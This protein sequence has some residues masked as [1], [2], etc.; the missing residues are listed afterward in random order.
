MQGALSLNGGSGREYAVEVT[1]TIGILL[2]CLV[3]RKHGIVI[4]GVALEFV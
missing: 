1:F 3:S 4:S 2:Y